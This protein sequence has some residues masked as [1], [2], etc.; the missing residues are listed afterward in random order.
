MGYVLESGYGQFKLV[1][2]NFRAHRIAF[3]LAT[4][5]QPGEWLVCHKCDNRL[6]CNPAHLFLGTNA[7][8]SADMAEKGR[9]A[10]QHGEKHGHAKLTE[11]DVVR[12]RIS[13]TTPTNI[14]VEYGVSPSLVCLI[15]RRA[16]WKHVA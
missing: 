2:K 13:E 10:K 5:R 7:D 15:R 14:A 8:N 3:F 16:I 6:C 12:I 11:E 9:A 1:S 4:G